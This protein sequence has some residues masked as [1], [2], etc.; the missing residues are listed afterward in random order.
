MKPNIAALYNHGSKVDIIYQTGLSGLGSSFHAAR[1]MIRSAHDKRI[2]ALFADEF[3]VASE[4]GELT[5]R[6]AL[7]VKTIFDFYLHRHGDR[8]VTDAKVRDGLITGEHVAKRVSALAPDTVASHVEI[9]KTARGLRQSAPDIS[10]MFLRICGY[11]YFYPQAFNTAQSTNIMAGNPE[12]PAAYVMANE[13][14]HRFIEQ[15]KFS[16]ID[17]YRSKV[18]DRLDNLIAQT[19]MD[20]FAELGN[21]HSADPALGQKRAELKTAANEDNAYGFAFDSYS[22]SITKDAL[23]NFDTF[24]ALYQR[25]LEKQLETAP[26]ADAK[27]LEQQIRA[28][29]FMTRSA[30]NP[31][32]VRPGTQQ[33]LFRARI[34]N[35][36]SENTLGGQRS[37]S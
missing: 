19:F 37:R 24:L 5:V 4:I 32:I 30:L 29:T 10:D 14:I 1:V 18:G 25:N 17:H 2:G 22:K 28:V 13:V 6:G 11:E 15:L 35:H 23:G 36:T 16:S 33:A 27:L 3:G 7:D 8:T 21:R 26:E 34:E 12:A 20:F 9:V 31:D